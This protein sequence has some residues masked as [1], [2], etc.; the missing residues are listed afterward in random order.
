MVVDGV[1]IR[2]RPPLDSP[3]VRLSAR[4]E[5]FILG[6]TLLSIGNIAIVAFAQLREVGEIALTIEVALTAIFAGD[7]LRRLTVAT[8]RRAYVLRGYGWLDL[9]GCLPG[10][11]LV[12]SIRV[13]RAFRQLG[14]YGG[15]RPVAKQVFAN[16]AQGSLLLVILV[17]IY[18]IE[19][20]SMAMLASETRSSD[21]N[22]TTSSDAL[23]YIMV[24][25][26]TVGYGDLYPTTSLGR[27]VG[28]VILVVGVGLFT[29]L[30]GFLANIFVN[31]TPR[32]SNQPLPPTD[33]TG[34]PGTQ[35]GLPSTT[36]IVAPETALPPSPIVTPMDR[37][38]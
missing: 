11:R 30:T 3:D 38:S 28:V 16:R 25:I 20:G 4:W 19:F 36:T 6:L 15:V 21:A 8:N 34:Q 7:F 18:V 17:A 12:R 10:L 27:V 13:A 23:W 35:T 37:R 9:I 26:S 5:A 22:I 29:T 14:D 24:T 2:D 31:P 1:P 32:A 33:S